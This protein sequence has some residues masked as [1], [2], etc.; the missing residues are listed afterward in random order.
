MTE[1]ETLIA[2][3]IG[4]SSVKFCS[5]SSWNTDAPAAFVQMIRE[6]CERAA[7]QLAER[8][9]QLAEPSYRS[10]QWC[11]ASV[12]RSSENQVVS[13][14]TRLRPSDRF[15]RLSNSEV[16]IKVNV[17][18]PNRV[19]IDRLLAAVAAAGLKEPDHAAIVI[20]VGSA[21]T[22]DFVSQ[23][24]VFQGG[25]ILPGVKLQSDSLARG[26]DALPMLE[27]EDTIASSVIG[28]STEHAIHAGVCNGL[29]GAVK[30]IVFQM[31]EKTTA[32]VFITGGDMELLRS[33]ETNKAQFI[34]D[35][36]PLG[37][38]DSFRQIAKH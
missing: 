1:C 33:M 20:D 24:S 23:D 29:V 36:V 26:T 16:P 21:V 28:K 13:E 5:Y 35:L 6:P 10:A 4:N 11:I 12:N 3:D 22:V 38:V 37:I 32:D 34:T 8:A 17:E 27:W 9:T 15:H 25:A 31:C 18:H 7:T 19:G 2:V 14:I 30:E